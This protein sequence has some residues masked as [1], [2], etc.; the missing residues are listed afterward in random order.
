MQPARHEV[1][2]DEFKQAFKD[3]HIP[4]GLMDRKMRE[5]LALKQGADT[6]YQ[7]AQKF[8]SLCQYGGHHV[9]TNAKKMECFCDGLDGDLYERLILL[10]PSSYHELVNKAIS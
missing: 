10:E 5:L 9:D 7:Y 3:H 6:V 8:N 4:K 1:T 2:W